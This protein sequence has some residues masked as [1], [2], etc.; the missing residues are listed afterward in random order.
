MVLAPWLLALGGRILCSDWRFAHTWLC[1]L[2][3][4][5]LE[6]VMVEEGDSLLALDDFDVRA[7]AFK[8][9]V[10]EV[11]VADCHLLNPDCGTVAQKG[12]LCLQCVLT[13]DAADL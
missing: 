9:A 10:R 4:A 6:G 1:W 8:L 11:A 12:V 13:L 5:E 2:K 3:L 7:F